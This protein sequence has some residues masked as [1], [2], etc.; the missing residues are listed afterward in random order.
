MPRLRLPLAVAALLAPLAGAPNAAGP[1][2]VIAASNRKSS[3]TAAN[4]AP[5]TGACFGRIHPFLRGAF[6]VAGA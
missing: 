5:G 1:V 6:R 3:Q 4:L 2:G